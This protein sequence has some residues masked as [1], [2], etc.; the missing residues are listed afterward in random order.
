MLF[1][2]PVYKSVLAHNKIQSLFKRTEILSL[3]MPFSVL[4]KHTLNLFVGEDT[5]KFPS[6]LCLWSWAGNASWAFFLQS[7]T[8]L[9]FLFIL[10]SWFTYRTFSSVCCVDNTELKE[11]NFLPLGALGF[12]MLRNLS[13]IQTLSSPLATD[14]S[15]LGDSARW[16]LPIRRGIKGHIPNR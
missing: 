3:R 4:S 12:E 15:I 10:A 9:K 2:P 1:L 7:Y 6:Y 8:I 5:V 14:V 11:F 16:T 13:P